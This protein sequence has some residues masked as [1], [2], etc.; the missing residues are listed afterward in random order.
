MGER[1]TAAVK[2]DTGMK[3]DMGTAVDMQRSTAVKGDTGMGVAMGM[4]IEVAR[5]YWRGEAVRFGLV[6]RHWLA[7]PAA[8]QPMC[9]IRYFTDINNNNN[10]SRI[11]RKTYTSAW[12]E[13]RGL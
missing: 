1:R 8:S 12:V 6:A 5:S 11:A 10:S 2:G 7:L 13:M 3:E 9:A 4:H